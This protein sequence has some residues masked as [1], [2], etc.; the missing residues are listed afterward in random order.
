MRLLFV[1]MAL[2][3]LSVYGTANAKQYLYVK[4]GH[5]TPA[6]G[7]S[8]SYVFDGHIVSEEG[9]EFKDGYIA[10]R[11]KYPTVTKRLIEN[12]KCS[13]FY[14]GTETRWN[15]SGWE[16]YEVDVRRNWNAFAIQEA[17]SVSYMGCSVASFIETFATKKEFLLDL[18]RRKNWH[19]MT[20][21]VFVP[22][23]GPEGGLGNPECMID[24]LE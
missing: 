18:Y 2:C 3:G 16:Q 19:L 7:D 17:G 11:G 20:A 6:S 24:E 4:C 12:P 1:I 5:L 9:P 13:K 21:D 10:I 23:V 22:R 8:I 14:I 15:D